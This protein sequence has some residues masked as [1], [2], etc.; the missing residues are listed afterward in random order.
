MP[1]FSVNGARYYFHAEGEGEPLVMLHGFTGSSESWSDYVMTFARRFL[2]IRIDLLGHG[3]SD[4]PAS[5]TRYSM[6]ASAEDIAALI[7]QVTS[8]PVHL[9][10][11]SMGGRLALYLAVTRPELVKSLI[12]ESASPGLKTEEERRER[13]E[14]DFQLAR[15]IE[16]DGIPSF[17]QRWERLPLFASQASLSDNL[18]QK[19]REQRLRNS[20]AGLAN[21]LRGMG[22]GIQ[23]SLWARLPVLQP[24]LLLLAGGLDQKFAELARQ[25]AREVPRAL[26]QVIPGA[27]HTVHLESPD[28]FERTVLQFVSGELTGMEIYGEV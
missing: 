9:M 28:P 17:V 18:R 12:L 10:G 7:G 15:S 23:P 26:L 13:R 2:L 6:E 1:Y 11:Y 19:L 8:L 3:M 4:A 14:R 21:S 24:P 16:Q 5:A 25:M 27:G 22:T 20:A